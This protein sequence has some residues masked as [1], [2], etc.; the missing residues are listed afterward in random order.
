[1]AL[2]VSRWKDAADINRA[3]GWV[4]EASLEKKRKLGAG[5]IHYMESFAW[6][7]SFS[8]HTSIV[9]HHSP[10][11]FTINP[12][13]IATTQQTQL[14]H[15]KWL[16]ANAKYFTDFLCTIHCRLFVREKCV[17]LTLF[18]ELIKLEFVLPM[19]ARF[20]AIS[21]SH[22]TQSGGTRSKHYQG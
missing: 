17:G 8:L 15:N 9:T 13:Y 19:S 4:S 7:R 12:S 11:L 16:H 10:L 14:L 6:A 22:P 1:M 5:C 18:P 3:T 2:P 20:T 21:E